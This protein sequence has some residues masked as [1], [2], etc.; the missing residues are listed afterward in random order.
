LEKL[1]KESKVPLLIDADGLNCLS[2]NKALLKILPK[3]S[4]LTP[5]LG[6]LERLIGKWKNDYDRIE[7]TK[8]FSAKYEVVVV[9]KGANTITVFD[10]KLYINTTGNPG[11][12][13][14][15]SGDVLSGAITG[16]LAQGY[17]PLLASVFG[18]YL[19]GSAGNIVSQQISFEAVMASD[20][21]ESLGAA[22]IELFAQDPTP[23][24]PESK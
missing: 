21:L 20:I 22:Y 2:E 12:A 23:P 5:H 9:M 1:L 3:H 13:T 24:L 14:A 10:N 11:M 8:K 16:L 6:E 7:K 4:V 17:D 19:H 18:V 15:G